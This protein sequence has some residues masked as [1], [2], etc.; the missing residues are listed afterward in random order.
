VWLPIENASFS[1]EQED[2]LSHFLKHK[3]KVLIMNHDDRD[4]AIIRTIL[5][6]ADMDVYRITQISEIDSKVKEYD[7][8]AV[9]ADVGEVELELLQ[10]CQSFNESEE[11]LPLILVQMGNLDLAGIAI[12]PSGI[13]NKPLNKNSLLRA[14]ISAGIPVDK[15]LTKDYSVLVV[16]DDPNS[17]E[18]ITT[19]LQHE[20][21][22]IKK[23]YSGDQA[24]TQLKQ[25]VPDLIIL[26]LMMPGVTGFD[27]V[28][29]MQ[30]EHLH[31][32]PVVIVTA[33]IITDDD[34]S[35]LTGKVR[36]IIEKYN[37]EQQGFVSYIEN[38]LRRSDD[39]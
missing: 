19:Y 34:V 1:A 22:D 35:Q 33:K 14:V 20:N 7:V 27:V 21:I 30:T 32:I 24:I 36:D 38:L 28:A 37:I 5:E 18:L 26:D 29:Y 8:D 3:K 4:A 39:R 23:A 11:S 16:D 31:D 13:V 15:P 2:S 6:E 9:I 12:K 25:A 10:Q 17:V